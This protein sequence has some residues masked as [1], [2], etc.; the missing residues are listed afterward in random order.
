MSMSTQLEE[1]QKKK[2]Q[3]ENELGSVDEE[4]SAIGASLELLEEKVE[5]RELED[6]VKAKRAVVEQL[7]AKKRNLENQ[8]G[9]H[10]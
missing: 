7:E 2:A 4:V 1:L 5:V 6:K 9:K 10:S 8:L 3:L